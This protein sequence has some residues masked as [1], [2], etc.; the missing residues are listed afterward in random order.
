[1]P[2][3]FLRRRQPLPKWKRR[4][5][6]WITTLFVFVL[7]LYTVLGIVERNVA[8]VL[9]AYAETSVKQVATDA[10]R[11]ALKE[12]IVSQQQFEGLIKFEKDN[13][14]QIQGVVIDQTNQTKL[15]EDTLRQIQKYLQ[16]DMYTRM[17]EQGLDKMS[18]YLGQAFKSRIFAD[19]G[20]SIPVTLMPQGAVE[21]SLN[22]TIESA[23]INM[24]LVNLMLNI[25]LDINVIVPFPTEPI[26]VRTTYP[27]ATAMVVG[28]TPQWYWNN[29]GSD[30]NMPTIPGITTEDIPE[31]QT[32]DL[33]GN[34]AW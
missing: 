12:Q 28:D 1:M 13:S 30:K 27:I 10:I 32:L 11:E 34:E 20:P 6:I 18:I 29:A 33:E 2:R 17:Q 9:R 24:V 15:H 7:T 23:G 16:D 26:T 25:K 4:L 31:E 19:T 21:V 3:F 22:P 14:G 5:I 8:P